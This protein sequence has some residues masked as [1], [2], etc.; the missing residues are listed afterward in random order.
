M[1]VSVLEESTDPILLCTIFNKYLCVKLF[2]FICCCILLV[3]YTD[4]VK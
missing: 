4:G 2:N 1:T 3:C